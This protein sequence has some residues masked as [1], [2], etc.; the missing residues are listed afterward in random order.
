MSDSSTII[1]EIQ[2][3]WYGDD[4]TESEPE[5]ELEPETGIEPD[6]EQTQTQTQNQEQEMEV[7]GSTNPAPNNGADQNTGSGKTRHK[8]K[9]LIPKA[10]RPVV[11]ENSIKHAINA[12][13]HAY[14][15]G[16]SF[17]EYEAAFELAARH[18]YNILESA[19]LDNNVDLFVGCFYIEPVVKDKLLYSKID[20]HHKLDRLISLAMFR[21]IQP[22]IV[23]IFLQDLTDTFPCHISQYSRFLGATYVKAATAKMVL[24]RAPLHMTQYKKDNAESGFERELNAAALLKL[25][26]MSQ[27]IKGFID[28]KQFEEAKKLPN[29]R[30]DMM[31]GIID[32]KTDHGRICA[33]IRLACHILSRLDIILETKN[34]KDFLTLMCLSIVNHD[35]NFAIMLLRGS[36]RSEEYRRCAFLAAAASGNH[37]IMQYTYEIMGENNRKKALV[38]LRALMIVMRGKEYEMAF[39]AISQLDMCVAERISVDSFVWI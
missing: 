23:F 11:R 17:S 6:S 19:I 7:E 29:M 9:I 31:D 24:R 21:E 35:N 13:L 25:S 1:S 36:C 5:Y 10:K 38:Y 15:S 32:A 28:I 26:C 22:I 20:V 14:S 37:V 12:I 4:E 16:R 18:I 2:Y 33:M 8:D 30:Q 39:F 34:P 3:N 27:T